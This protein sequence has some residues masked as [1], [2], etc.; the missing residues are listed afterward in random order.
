[1]YQDSLALELIPPDSWGHGYGV[2]L[3]PVDAH[4]PIPEVGLWE[5]TLTPVSLEVA[6]K[7]HITGI[8]E[9]LTFHA[10]EPVG[11]VQKA[12]P[13]PRRQVVQPPIDI[14][15]KLLVQLD[16]VVKVPSLH[17][18]FDHTAEKALPGLQMQ[19]MK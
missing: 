2:Q 12:D 15:M 18:G 14:T 16:S 11:L 5:P 1:M 17:G 13:V 6:A 9:K 8:S 3:S 10:G 19:H 7:A 4:R